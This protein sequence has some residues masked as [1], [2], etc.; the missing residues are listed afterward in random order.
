MV[1]IVQNTEHTNVVYTLYTELLILIQNHQG[2]VAILNKY[3]SHLKEALQL[4]QVRPG[5][6]SV[7]AS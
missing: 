1:P 3:R 5:W 6:V 4:L 7:L 2:P